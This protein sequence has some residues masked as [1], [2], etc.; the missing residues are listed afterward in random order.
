LDD[1]LAKHGIG[2]KNKGELHLL[3]LTPV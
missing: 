2:S 3:D 1:H